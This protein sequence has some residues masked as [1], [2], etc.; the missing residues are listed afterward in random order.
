[1]ENMEMKPWKYGGLLDMKEL[2]K[3]KAD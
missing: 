3:M 2:E 1:M